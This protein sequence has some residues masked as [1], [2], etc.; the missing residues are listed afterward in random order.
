M[1]FD[2]YCFLTSLPSEGAQR[3]FQKNACLK[4]V[5]SN[6]KDKA[7]L[8]FLVLGVGEVANGVFEANYYELLQMLLFVKKISFSH[9]AL[10]CCSKGRLTRIWADILLEPLEPRGRGAIMARFGHE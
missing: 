2:F 6:K 10:V 9:C 1:T 7:F 5:H 3:N 8:G 4:S